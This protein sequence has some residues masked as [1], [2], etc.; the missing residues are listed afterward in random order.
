MKNSMNSYKNIII[1]GAA[2][3]GKSTLAHMLH[4]NYNYSIISIDSFV[5]AL[6]DAF[7]EIGISHS[8][9]ENK[10]KLLP[11][12][13][14]SYMEKIV[15][16][17][18]EERFVLEGWHVYPNDIKRLF[19][20]LDVKLICLGYTEIS[21]DEVFEIIRKNE[22]ENEYTKKMTDERLKTLISNHIEYSK[23]L[24]KQC[25]ESN[26]KFYDTSFNRNNKLNEIMNVLIDK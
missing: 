19:H 23:M 14:L 6:H 8:N 22:G 1:L 25:E 26:I 11:Q 15:N 20:N 2:R 13:L 7:P 3:S 18:P 16:E 24:K 12:F 17:Y 9:T 10:F 21:C 5:S 4:R